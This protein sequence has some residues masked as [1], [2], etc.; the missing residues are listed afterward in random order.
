MRDETLLN[1]KCAINTVFAC[2][3]YVY[4]YLQCFSI[5]L[6]MSQKTKLALSHI[7]FTRFWIDCENIFRGF[8]PI[9]CVYYSFLL[10][11]LFMSRF[12]AD[13][14]R[15]AFS[16]ACLNVRCVS[17]CVCVLARRRAG[18][19]TER[20]LQTKISPCANRCA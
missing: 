17:V 18:G 1:S 16:Y 14:S 8:H 19:K 13:I 7:E 11:N 10:S 12:V 4:V 9:L 3:K 6:I 2:R 20:P 5:F 15:D